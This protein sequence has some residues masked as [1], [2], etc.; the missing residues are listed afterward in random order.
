MALKDVQKT[1]EK[2]GKDDPLF[3]VLTDSKFEGGKWDED[4]LFKNGQDEID[5]SIQYLKELDVNLNYDGTVMDFGCGVGRLTQALNEYFA[6]TLGIDI[7]YSMVESAQ[8]YNKYGERC[9][10]KVN[11]EADLKLIES[12]SLDFIYSNITLQHSPPEAIRCYVAEFVR[13][14]KPGGYAHFQIPSGMR[15]KEG[16][17]LQKL[18]DIK[19]GPVRR[20]WK[21]IRGKQP[22]EIHY[23]NDQVVTE[24]VET[25]GAKVLD[26]KPLPRTKFFYTIQKDPIN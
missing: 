3:A 10:Y 19:R 15:M 9:Q 20:F 6:N 14:L 25:S 7:S 5:E 13:T 8:N 18:Y 26:K 2:F 16:G 24:I 1:Y 4:D 11:T 22:V 12:E 21:R 23:L 17:V